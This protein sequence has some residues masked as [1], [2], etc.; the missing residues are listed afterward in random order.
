MDELIERR[1]HTIRIVTNTEA[2]YPQIVLAYQKAN[3]DYQLAITFATRE[4]CMNALKPG[5]QDF[6][7]CSPP[8]PDDSSKGIVT[9]IVFR[10][11]PCVMLPPGHPMLT[12]KS[13]NF[14]DMRALCR[15]FR[16]ASA[17]SSTPATLLAFFAAASAIVP[18]PQ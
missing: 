5:E 18:M 6:A 10:E 4:E 13:V 17:E 7:I 3:P 2:H 14:D 16:T 15:A 9:D 12:R 1:S 8:L 11:K